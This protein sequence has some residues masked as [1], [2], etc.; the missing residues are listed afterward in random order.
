MALIDLFVSATLD[1]VKAKVAGFADVA[2]LALTSWYPG[3]PGEQLYQAFTQTMVFYIG[4]NSQ[5]ARSFFLDYA[6]DPGDEDPY[7]PLNVTLPP[8]PGFLSALGLNC[9]FTERPGATFA[10][11]VLTVTNSTAFPTAPFAPFALTVARAGH[12]EVTYRNGPDPTQ[13]TGPGGT[14]VIPAGGTVFLPFTAETPGTGFNVVPNELTASVTRP[15]LVVNN[16]SAA[17]GAD[18]MAADVYRALC[19]T[20]AAATSPNGAR[21]AYRRAATTNLDG[22]PLLRAVEFGGDGVTPVNITKVYDTGNSAT[23]KV[24]VYY[25]DEDGDVDP[26]DVLTANAN[27]MRN[28]IV[29]PDAITFGPSNTPGL[30]GGVAAIA[31]NVTPVWAVEYLTTYLGRPVTGG[32]VRA[33]IIAALTRR[34][35]FYPI[36]GFKRVAGAGTIDFDDINATIKSAHPAII[37]GGL[38]TPATDVAIALGHFARL[39]SPDGTETG[40]AP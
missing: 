8:V 14:L 16:P 4:G 21:D 29:S 10:T 9:F 20:Q 1:D 36:G 13:Y 24:D 35:A 23:G 28:V 32:V 3:A 6:T 37:T 34:F 11:T 33:A 31:T 27:I 7:D 18:R 2:K 17:T 12:P 40:V 30:L 39:T 38:L 22:T 19:R 25:G 5:I 26:V 15:G